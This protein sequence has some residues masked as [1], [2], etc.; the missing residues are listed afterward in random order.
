M[1]AK[2]YMTPVPFSST[3]I[4]GGVAIS[5]S[6][7]VAISLLLHRRS[8]ICA[9]AGDLFLHL[10]GPLSLVLVRHCCRVRGSSPQ[11]PPL[12]LALSAAS[13]QAFHRLEQSDMRSTTS[14]RDTLPSIGMPS[15]RTTR[16]RPLSPSLSL[17]LSFSAILA[18]SIRSKG[19]WRSFLKIKGFLAQLFK[20]QRVLGGL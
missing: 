16:I 12:D 11:L 1:R 10:G 14:T 7:L 5:L 2:P 20:D 6:V 15:T 17:L 9:S 18:F 8:R 4:A 19:S 13:L 3:V